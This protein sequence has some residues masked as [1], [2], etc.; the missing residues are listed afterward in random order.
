MV[1]CIFVSMEWA[2]RFGEAFPGFTIDGP[3]LELGK[4]S[5][6]VI[7]GDDASEAARALVSLSPNVKVVT[8][9]SVSDLVKTIEEVKTPCCLLLE[10]VEDVQASRREQA[11]LEDAIRHHVDMWRKE[12]MRV[13]L[14]VS[15]SVKLPL[16]VMADSVI[17]LP[18]LPT[19]R[20]SLIE[21]LLP[22]EL[23]IASACGR[24]GI[25]N[26]LVDFT[27]FWTRSDIC[28]L[29][30]H[31][32][33]LA[34][35]SDSSLTCDHVAEAHRFLFQPGS[36]AHQVPVLSE[37]STLHRCSI[38][39]QESFDS[40]EG[41]TAAVADLT[42]A[43]KS[44]GVRLL[45]I[46]G[47]PGTGKSLLARLLVSHASPDIK[48]DVLKAAEVLSA[49]VGESE[50]RLAGLLKGARA[51]IIE[52][53][54]QLW[55]SNDEVTG[56]VQRLL[57][58][59]LHGLDHLVNQ[60]SCLIVMTS[61]DASLVHPRV[62]KRVACSV[63][64]DSHLET[65]SRTRL[66]T[67]WTGGREDIAKAAASASKGFTGASCSKMM[68]EAGIRAI[69]RLIKDELPIASLSLEDFI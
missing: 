42:I 62:M 5:L 39:S 31:S 59:L 52:D 24:A 7:R 47:D 34:L 50:K 46:C 13:I 4:A 63:V 8:C 25:V 28:K 22:K 1:E 38:F 17:T 44:S 19:C 27:T 51:L 48:V 40:F 9:H 64:L 53:A 35:A 30:K 6:C 14:M 61:R 20:A 18:K 29:V 37:A 36:V 69:K 68:R 55:P 43:T 58:T 33:L 12:H 67:K 21:S 10:R 49:I 54:D 23:P 16:E 15:T 66:F 41:S 11:F 57:P 26:A 32:C 60:D 45:S 65:D 2:H 56:A 3:K